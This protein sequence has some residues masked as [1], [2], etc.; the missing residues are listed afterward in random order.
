MWGYVDFY[1]DQLLAEIHGMEGE[2]RNMFTADR[3]TGAKLDYLDKSVARIKREETRQLVAE[4]CQGAKAVL[5][6]RNFVIHGLWAFEWTAAD[7]TA[8]PAAFQ[9]KNKKRTG[10][11]K[12]IPRLHDAIAA[13]THQGEKASASMHQVSPRP[14]PEGRTFVFHD[15]DRQQPKSPLRIEM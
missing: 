9:P 15:D 4:F 6:D 3:M 14:A 2:W 11:P 12:D 5:S 10:Y 1:V 13:V 7:E 8:R